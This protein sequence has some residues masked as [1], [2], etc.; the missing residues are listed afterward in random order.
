M[1]SIV[2]LILALSML[3]QSL[4]GLTQQC[5]AMPMPAGKP[6]NAECACCHMA[7]GGGRECG[8]PDSGRAACN[9]KARQPDQPKTPPPDSKQQSLEQVLAFVPVLV[10]V[11]P[12]EP[13]TASGWRHPVEP[14]LWRSSS[15]AQSLLCVWLM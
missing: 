6:A 8:L 15:S 4:P 5:A 11:L 12:F 7:T 13:P 3:M 2:T 10:A 9:C 14:R 1:R